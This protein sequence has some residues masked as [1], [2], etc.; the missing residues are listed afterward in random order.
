MG[1]TCKPIG[2]FRGT[3]RKL[4]NQLDKEKAELVKK[5]KSSKSTKSKKAN[6]EDAE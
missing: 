1:I 5:G 6:E 2:K 4:Q 3:M